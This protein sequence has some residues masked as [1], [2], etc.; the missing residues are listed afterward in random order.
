MMHVCIKLTRQRPDSEKQRWDSA[1]IMA[2]EGD[3]RS[4]ADGGV[5]LGAVGETGGIGSGASGQVVVSS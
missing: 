1:R 5:V 2:G 4:T 3:V